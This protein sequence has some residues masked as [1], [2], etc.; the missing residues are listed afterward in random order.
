MKLENVGDE[1]TKEGPIN[2]R[3]VGIARNDT[4]PCFTSDKTIEEESKNSSGDHAD[5]NRN[6]PSFPHCQIYQG[7]H[8]KVN[9]GIPKSAQSRMR[10]SGASARTEG[11][12]A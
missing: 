7:S 6:H 3:H 5:N 12:L 2:R 8:T 9:Q 11:G 4:S 1:A 10:V